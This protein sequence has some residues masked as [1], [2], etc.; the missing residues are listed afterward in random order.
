MAHGE[1]KGLA[2]E[3]EKLFWVIRAA[4]GQVQVVCD[5]SGNGFV[6]FKRKKQ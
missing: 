6:I 3:R 4:R 1:K 5:L 2:E